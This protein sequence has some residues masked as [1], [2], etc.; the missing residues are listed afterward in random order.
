MIN[1]PIIAIVGVSGSGKSS[2]IENLDPETT[3]ILNIEN[4]MLPFKKALEFAHNVNL[5]DAI[6]LDAT[7]QRFLKDPKIKT[8]V[9]ESFS[10]YCDKVAQK[11]KTVASGWEIWNYYNEKIYNLLDSSKD[12][13]G[14]FIIFIC[15]DEVIK[16]MSS[17]GAETTQRRIKVDGKKLEGKVEYHFPI[18][19]YTL[20]KA[21]KDK[22]A[23]YHFVTNTDGLITAKSPKGMFPT[24]INNDLSLV[25]KTCKEYYGLA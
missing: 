16:I 19:L 20:T 23:T 14:K 11:A 1:Y 17:S 25:L 6:S 7:L 10:S 12:N 22:P 4:K 21:D 18:V 13:N 3:A 9:I 15:I 24:I 8:I 5:T 2:S